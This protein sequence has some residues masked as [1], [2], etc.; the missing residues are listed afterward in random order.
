MDYLKNRDAS[1][2]GYYNTTIMRQM[3]QKIIFKNTTNAVEDATFLN[4]TAPTSTV[5]Q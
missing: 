1:Q 5:V 4:D 2:I 3:G